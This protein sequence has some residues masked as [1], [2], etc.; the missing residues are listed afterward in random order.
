M[1]IETLIAIKKEFKV[2]YQE[3]SEKSGVPI[4]TIQKVMS[5]LTVPRENTMKA[6]KDSMEY[7]IKPGSPRKMGALSFKE[8]LALYGYDDLLDSI[9]E[10]RKNISEGYVSEGGVKY[11]VSSNAK[12]LGKAMNRLD[13]Y[14]I[15]EKDAGEYTVS[16]Y[17]KLPDGVRV[18]LIEGY[19]YDMAAPS[20]KHQLI[21][22]EM[23]FQLKS[24]I[25]KNK[26]GCSVFIAP[27]DV[28][29]FDDDKTMVQPDLFILC[30]KDMIRE[31]ERTHGAP[32][33]VVE[34]ISDSS[35]FKDMILK[36]NLY[37]KAG[38]REYWIVD[39]YK[40]YV[41]TYIFDE[42]EQTNIYTFEDNIPLAIYDGKISVDFKEIKN[43]LIERFGV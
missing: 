9:K 14:S 33:F 19:L 13:A 27:S 24:S 25:K 43:E 6:L 30:K 36:L 39:P 4:S 31:V 10:L 16:D 23:L 18:E 20:K 37:S 7:F 28:Q 42:N 12:S 40:G 17:E 32:D 15:A 38:V 41:I 11:N 22:Q 3:I 35:R 26:G 1:N 8:L 21:L 34:V 29:L 5:E 2:T